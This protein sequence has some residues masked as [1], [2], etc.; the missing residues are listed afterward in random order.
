MTMSEKTP[1]KQESCGLSFFQTTRLFL[2]HAFV[3]LPCVA[4][5]SEFISGDSLQLTIAICLYSSMRKKIKNNSFFFPHMQFAASW[6]LL[7][8]AVHFVNVIPL[9]LEC[10]KCLML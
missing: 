3:P 1:S 2:D 10:I 6:D 9:N 5:R 7:F 4:D 8:G